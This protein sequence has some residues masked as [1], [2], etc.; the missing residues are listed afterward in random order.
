MAI[1]S[2]IFAT[3]RNSIVMAIVDL[4]K[5]I[6]G[7]GSGFLVDLNGQVFPKMQF[8]EDVTDFPA[9]CVVASNETREYQAA[10]YRDRYLDIR[11]MLYIKE[12]KALDKC[13]ALLEDIE[14]IL[15]DNSALTYTKRD[16]TTDKT[17]DITVLSIGTDEGT[18][19]PISIGEI[20]V[21]VHY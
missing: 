7:S 3:R 2:R 12:D 15:E 17:K 10:G 19:E 11:I 18:L 1:T 6:R 16:G 13:E 20:M 9:V 14:T 21:R 8:F 4:L 5:T